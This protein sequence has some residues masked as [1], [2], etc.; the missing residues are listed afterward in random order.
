MNMRLLM[1]PAVVEKPA[2]ATAPAA[3]APAPATPAAPPA[4]ATPPKVETASA[5]VEAAPWA[6][7]AEGKAAEP[8]KAA[9]SNDKKEPEKYSLKAPDG[10]SM[11]AKALETFGAQMQQLG[12]T[13]DQAQKLLEARHA[14]QKAAEADGWKA[15]RAQDQ[16]WLSELQQDKE[17]GLANFGKNAERTKRAFDFID[18]DGSMRREMADIGVSN[19]PKLMKGLAKFG[20]RMEEDNLHT[21]ANGVPAEKDKRSTNQKLIDSYR[22]QNQVQAAA[23]KG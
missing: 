6:P 12:V 20:A 17:Y 15:I 16:K 19:W 23:R 1:D 4:T 9:E 11:D 2:G 10:S 5:A 21:G 8:A 22:Q 7:P 13:Q 18:P 3:A 14:E